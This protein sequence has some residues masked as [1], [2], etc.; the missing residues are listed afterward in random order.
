[1]GIFEEKYTQLN[2]EQRTAVDTIDGPVLVLAGPGTGK[3]QLLSLR[4][5]NILKQTDT[6]P[7]NVLCLTFTENGAQNMRNRLSR[8]IGQSAYDVNINTYHALGGELIRRYP[9]YFEKTRGE[10]PI[11]DIGKHQILEKIISEMSYLNPLKQTQHHLGDLMSTISDLKRGLLSSADIQAIGKQ[12]EAWL[13]TMDAS[14]ADIFS[15]FTRM[16]SKLALARPYFDAILETIGK[17][18]ASN[19]KIG[20]IES[21]S[22]TAEQS[23]QAALDV[24]ETSGKTAALTAWK[25]DWLS[26]D[27][28]NNFAMNGHLQ[29]RRFTAL[30]KV[31]DDYQEALSQNGL[32]DFDDM[33]V[34]SIEALE[35]NDDFRYSLQ[36]QYLYILLDEFQDTNAAQLRLVELLTN[37]PITEG[38]PNVLAVGD[39][40]Q[41]IYA[42]QG[43][44]VSNMI[45]F[46]N[47][48][49]DVTVI[50]LTENYR[51][52]GDILHVAHGIAGQ[53]ETRL[54]HHFEHLNKTL[55]AASSTLPNKATLARHEFQ[56]DIASFDWISQK[57]AA[58][59]ADGTPASEIAILAPKHKYLEPIVPFLN[60]RDIPVRYEKRENILEAPIV[61]QIIAMSRLVLALQSGN[62]AFANS[63]WPQVLS[64]DFWQ[65]SAIAI[66][67]TSW[68]V[69]DTRSAWSKELLEQPDLSE[70]ATLFLTIALKAEQE[71]LETMLDMLIGTTKVTTND[72]DNPT[73]QSPLREYYTNSAYQ[74]ENPDAFYETLSHLTVLRKKL[75]EH[76]HTQEKVLRLHDLLGFVDLYESANK[77][78]LNTSP[79]NQHADAVQMMTVFKAKGLEFEYVFLPA[80]QDEVWGNAARQQ[81]NRLTLPTNLTPIRPA[82]TTPDERLRIFFVAITRARHGL[83]MVSA[84]GDYNGKFSKR[85]AYLNEQDQTDGSVHSLLLPENVQKIQTSDHTPPAL[86]SLEMN[87]QTK[88]NGVS[89]TPQITDL[90][91]ERIEKYQMSPTHLNSFTDMVYGGPNAFFF[92]TILRFPQAPTPAGQ[93]GNAIHETL[94]W[95]QLELNLNHPFPDITSVDAMFSTILGSKKLTPE[96]T[97]LM[98]E[99]GLAALKAYLAERADTFKQGDIPE[100]DFK[101]EGVFVNGAHMSGKIDV[102]RI[103]RDKKEITIVDYKTGKSYAKWVSD[104]KLHKYKQQLYCYKLLIEH[105]HSYAGYVVKQAVLEFIEPDENGVIQSLTLEFKPD[106]QRRLENLIGIVWTHIMALN[107]PDVSSYRKD[108]AD[109]KRFEQDLLDGTI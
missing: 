6:L 8:F 108:I 59:I 44:N 65:F 38:R 102:L 41:A 27:A 60:A 87:W 76:Q 15:S 75:R 92:N 47:L 49:R 53:I 81:S 101:H 26:K 79:Y 98:Q 55:N 23:L 78:L 83:F 36:E 2:R 42:F 10:Q 70:A 80:C 50:N 43:A 11:D 24:A 39:D 33:I 25:N 68:K 106:E 61:L 19:K 93:F 84:A 12:N 99:R 52:H 31:L 94:E 77:Q 64:F 7:Q 56:S 107:L 85:L 4:V 104:I 96:T 73:V 95:I 14:I 35:Q 91:K 3:T 30:A 82:G 32:Y 17:H 105:S 74:K 88:H 9:E 21:L 16:P 62:E 89:M 45:D 109:T 37:N 13:T 63:L 51:S 57:I 48:Y 97:A 54:H 90:L 28:N 46:Y 18:T 67:K 29:S 72:E 71:S 103:D 86:E 69:N 20:G 100:A 5:A 58:L 66:W 40:D 34:R 1:M 22:A